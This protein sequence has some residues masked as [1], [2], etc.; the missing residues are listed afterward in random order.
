L[1]ALADID[2]ALLAGTHGEAAALAMRLLERYAAALGAPG[3]ID[4]SAAHVDG[5]LYHGEVS[6]DVEAAVDRALLTLTV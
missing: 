5:C 3:F 2:R 4:V 6:L 1:T